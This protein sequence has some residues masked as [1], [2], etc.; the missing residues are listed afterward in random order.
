MTDGPFET[1]RDAARAARAAVPPEEG[2]TVLSAA[3]NRQLLGRALEAAGVEMGRYDD[4][5]AEWLAGF[6]DSACA[7]IAGW[8]TRAYAAGKSAPRKDGGDE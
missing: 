3:Q 7:V 5:I 8:V 1:Y 2:W 4:R 6:E